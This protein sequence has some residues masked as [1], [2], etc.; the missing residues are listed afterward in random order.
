MTMWDEVWEEFMAMTFSE[1]IR[2]TGRDI[3]AMVIGFG[4]CLIIWA[5]SE[6]I[7]KEKK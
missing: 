2:L 3:L 7:R 4:T 5:F 6:A 1:Y